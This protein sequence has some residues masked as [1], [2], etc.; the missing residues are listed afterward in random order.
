MGIERF[1]N[2][3]FAIE[4]IPEGDTFTVV[5]SGLAR[6]LGQRDAVDLVRTIPAD[7]KGYGVVR[8][9][10]GEQNVLVL[11]E[12]G[13][14]RA[15]GQRQAARVRDLS[16][17]EQVERFQSWVFGDVLPQIRR[18]GRFEVPSGPL[19]ELAEIEAAN[20]R[21]ARAVEIA[22]AE[23]ARAVAAEQQVR[24][25]EPAARSW[26]V[27]ASANGDWSLRDA[28]LILN[29][30]A[31]IRTGQNRLNN[32]LFELGM[33]DRRGTPYARHH[34]HLVERPRTYTDRATQEERQARPQIRI[35]AAGLAYLHRKLGGTDPLRYE[36]PLADAG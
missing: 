32:L 10:G 9:P 35:T 20:A 23:R 36:D 25:L 15:I 14:Y 19:D 1:A 22:K 30:D 7:E 33:V 21:S 4:V 5:A 18:T 12:P 16:V 27:L 24:A 11:K 13:F 29:R 8:T 28:A 6:A 17:R 2:G 31:S 3:E 26:D 34:A